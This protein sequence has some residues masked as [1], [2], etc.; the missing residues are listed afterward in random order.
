MML[1]LTCEIIVVVD[2]FIA[3]TLTVVRHWDSQLL[4]VLQTSFIFLIRSCLYVW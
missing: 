1:Y 3:I 2:C 4:Y